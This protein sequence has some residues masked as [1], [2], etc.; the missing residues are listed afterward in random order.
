MTT[1]NKLS[2][3]W[4]HSVSLQVMILA[5]AHLVVATGGNTRSLMMVRHTMAGNAV[6]TSETLGNTPEHLQSVVDGALAR[7]AHRWASTLD[8]DIAPLLASATETLQDSAAGRLLSQPWL[9]GLVP[10]EDPQQGSRGTNGDPPLPQGTSPESPTATEIRGVGTGQS[11]LPAGNV[12]GTWPPQFASKDGPG[13]SRAP[14]V[15]AKGPARDRSSPEAT[16]VSPGT[17]AAPRDL[18][19]TGQD[20]L[21][22]DWSAPTAAPVPASGGLAP[23][24]G[25]AKDH[26][27]AETVLMQLLGI[28]EDPNSYVKAPVA[29]PAVGI[30]AHGG[31]PAPSLEKGSSGIASRGDNQEQKT[32]LPPSSA[33]QKVVLPPSGAPKVAVPPPIEA[34]SSKIVQKPGTAPKVVVPPPIE[35]PSSRLILPPGIAPKT[36]VQPPLGAHKKVV[37]P[38]GTAPKGVVQPPLEA[39]RVVVLPPLEAQ[40]V[41]LPPGAAPEVAVPP[42]IKAHKNVVPP[43]GNAQRVVL[44]PSMPPQEVADAPTTVEEPIPRGFKGREI[45]VT[46]TR[47][48]YRVE[49]GV[50]P[51]M[52]K[53]RQKRPLVP[54]VAPESHSHAAPSPWQHQVEVAGPSPASKGRRLPDWAPAGSP[55]GATEELELAKEIESSVMEIVRKRRS[56]QASQAGAPGPSPWSPGYR[57]SGSAD[58][59]ISGSPVNPSSLAGAIAIAIS[60]SAFGSA[61]SSA[62]AGCDS[63][64]CAPTVAITRVRHAKGPAPTS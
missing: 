28:L 16:Q 5:T 55:T 9:T 44:P 61:H 21:K 2:V 48:S 46:V 47:Q 23:D 38:P 1:S 54:A 36:A 18:A 19:W 12:L 42:P 53:T 11:E 41:V 22:K 35:A 39:Q 13:P 29:Q 62:D 60:V 31:I 14:E 52:A 40:K 33:E 3:K 27:I 17:G 20:A 45:T 57:A 24:G 63:G 59:S 50:P 56:G 26:E 64:S 51:P 37:L 43:P 6:S 4:H 25:P 58:A 15:P 30:L 8:D 32:A 34:P 49:S 7:L 10:G